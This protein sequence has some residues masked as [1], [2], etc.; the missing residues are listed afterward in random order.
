MPSHRSYCDCG[1]KAVRPSKFGGETICER[2]YEAEELLGQF[3]ED[4]T[5]K[6]KKTKG[7][8]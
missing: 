2:C 7:R 4:Y 5:K 8:K 6:P 3:H 1:R